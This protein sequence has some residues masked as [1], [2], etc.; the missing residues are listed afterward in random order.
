M[1][2]LIPLILYSTEYST[3]VLLEWC[4]RALKTVKGY[5]GIFFALF[6]FQRVVLTQKAF[7]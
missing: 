5:T 2:L 4:G 3:I 6:P 7:L 1:Y